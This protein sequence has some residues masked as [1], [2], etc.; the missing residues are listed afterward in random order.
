MMG[1][2]ERGL[3]LENDKKRI[4]LFSNIIIEICIPGTHGDREAKDTEVFSRGPETPL[5]LKEEF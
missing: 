1:L 5:T 3:W 4:T 2:Q